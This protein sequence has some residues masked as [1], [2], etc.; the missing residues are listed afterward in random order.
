MKK[1]RLTREHYAMMQTLV[2]SIRAG[3]TML[4]SSGVEGKYTSVALKNLAKEIRK[5]VTVDQIN[6][7]R[8]FLNIAKMVEK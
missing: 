5:E 2:A 4:E 1:V 7:L 6:N 8:T 3:S